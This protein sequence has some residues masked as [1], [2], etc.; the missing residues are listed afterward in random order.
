MCV[1][2]TRIDPSFRRSELHWLGVVDRVRFRVCVQVFRCLQNT[3]PEYLSTLC[4]PVFGVPGRRHLRSADRGH[5]DF[6]RVRLATYLYGGRTS[7]YAG[8]RPSNWDSLPAHLR[9]NIFSL[10]VQLPH[11]NFYL[12]ISTCSAFGDF[13]LRKT[14]YPLLSFSLCAE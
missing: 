1:S 2:S 8:Q 11:K 5:L 12:S 3:A 6:R 7:A 14:R 9:Y 10:N 13:I 4:Q